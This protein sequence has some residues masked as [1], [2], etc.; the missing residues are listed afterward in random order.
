ML[1]KQ[2]GFTSDQLKGNPSLPALLKFTPHNLPVEI[3]ENVVELFEKKEAGCHALP[4]WDRVTL[5]RTPAHLYDF[6]K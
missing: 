3:E 5:T 4:T 6:Y 1:L 2:V